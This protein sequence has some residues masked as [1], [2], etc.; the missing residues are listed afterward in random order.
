[1]ERE[2]QAKEKEAANR[3]QLVERNERGWIERRRE[4]YCALSIVTCGYCGEEGTTEAGD[5]VR[6]ECVHD[7]W[8]K[9]CRPKKEWLDR[10]VAAGKRSKMRCTACGKKWVAAKKEEVEAGECNKCEDK[11]RKKEAAQPRE[12]KT[13]QA[14]QKRERDLRHTL[15]PLNGVWITIGMEKVDTHEGVT[16]KALLDSRATGMFADRKFVE[17]MDSS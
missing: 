2:W 13:Q 3:G 8:C 6:I 1:M 4:E 5:F 17:R 10:E 16:V 15:Q 12:V 14:E 9:R 11:R 7:M